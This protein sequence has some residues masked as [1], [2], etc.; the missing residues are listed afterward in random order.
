[1][2]ELKAYHPIISF[3]YFVLVIGF[4]MFF[5][6][7]IC[8]CISLVFSF[9]YS[10][11]LGGA[12]AVKRSL[13]YLVPTVIV[14]ALINPLFN[15]EGVTVITY[16]ADS[17]PLTLESTV[18]G[19]AAAVMLASVI[20]W[21][22]CCNDIMT[23][24]KIIY[25]FGRIL[26]SLSLIFSMVLRFVPRFAAQLKVIIGAQKCIG[27]D[28]SSPNLV[29]KAKNGLTI[30]SAMV[31]WA[32]ENSIETADSMRARGYGLKGRTA[33]S[34][35]R[36]DRRDKFALIGILLSGGIV[37]YG[38]IGGK[39]SFGFFP[40]LKMS[41]ISLESIICFA[42]YGILCAYPLIIELWEVKKWSS[43]KSKG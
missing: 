33:F 19:A 11:M 13:V 23:S 36:F 34:V 22:S 9:I 5:M 39:M 10:S 16:L 43:I 41:K 17:N 25:L 3:T 29:K 15:H 27:K 30:L 1:M 40:S 24:D 31:S 2:N 7:P 20:L 8:L 12:R 42:A 38:G 28:M 26:P 18:Y 35:F 14:T 32:L 21:F 4:S 6:H 37:L